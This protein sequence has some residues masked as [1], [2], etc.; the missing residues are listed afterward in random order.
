MADAYWGSP[1]FWASLTT[2]IAFVAEVGFFS[3][4]RN[5]LKLARSSLLPF[6]ILTSISS[7]TTLGLD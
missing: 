1:A 4:R 5:A 6:K 2:T 7:D 3:C